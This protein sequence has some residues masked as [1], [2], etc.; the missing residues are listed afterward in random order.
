MPF[1]TTIGNNTAVGYGFNL[2]APYQISYLLVAGGGGG[3]GGTNAQAGGGGG[4]AGGL[5]TSSFTAIPK[6]V[7]PWH[8]ASR[9][10]S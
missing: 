3:G 2:S 7:Y 1:I 9:T 4:G 6:T 8:Q 5:L 10:E